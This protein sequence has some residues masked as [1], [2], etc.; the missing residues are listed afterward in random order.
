[1]TPELLAGARRVAQ[2]THRRLQL[3]IPSILAEEEPFA[4]RITSFG[5]DALPAAFP[6]EIVLAGSPGIQ[7]LP[8]S[9]RLDAASEGLFT[10][11]GLRAAGAE[12]VR[13]GA[14]VEE[15]DADV[16]S[17]PAW[18]YKHP[19]Y[20]LYWG[21]LHIHTSYSN[22][23]A[24]SCRDPEFGYEYAREASHLD[25]AAAAD[26]LRGIVAEAERWD[27]L[28]GLARKFDRPGGFA[29][30]LGFESSHRSGLGGDN[31]AYFRD[32][33]GP[34]FWLDREDMKGNNPAVSVEEL[35]RFLEGTG[36][37]FITIPHHTG[38]Y[39][40]WRAFDEGPYNARREPL[41]EIYSMWG[42]SDSP[43][44]RFPLVAGNS[45]RAA[46][47]VDALHAGC[48]YGVI[49][50]S[51]DHTTLPGG[52]S[53]NWG[54]A[55]GPQAL[56]G[57]GHKG[58]AAVRAREL[59]REALWSAF[60]ARRTY[61]STF[62]RTPLDVRL[63]DLEMGQAARLD[64]RDPLRARREARVRFTLDG[65]GEAWVFLLRNGVEC[66]RQVRPWRKTATPE[67]EEAILEDPAPLA[68][69]ALRGARFHP[70]PFV[71]YHARLEVRGREETLWS[72]P[73]WLDL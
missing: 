32:C 12:A 38:R 46:Y 56:G 16:Q 31:N 70:E 45:P 3:T 36:R 54:A 62:P 41:F 71:C 35:W 44:S 47:F 68:D 57:Y 34:C 43:S 13:V 30:F 51:D 61:A 63:G 73:I 28:R 10:V 67:I 11:P 1:M 29:A 4:L 64:A 58:L 37:E 14:R 39:G 60:L 8:K 6:F 40:K 66:A 9:V 49:A 7:G 69:V 27:R 18:V 48:R 26:H 55:L 33:E 59:T 25:F 17:N 50:S 24:W 19:P 23:Q 42:G 2:R 53:R 22:C 52:E 65:R 5:P 21:D 72:S 15:L 20:R